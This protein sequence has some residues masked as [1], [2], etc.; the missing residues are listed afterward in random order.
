VCSAGCEVAVCLFLVCGSVTWVALARSEARRVSSWRVKWG[1]NVEAMRFREGEGG[2]W[3]SKDYIQESI[4]RHRT[5]QATTKA[6]RS[7]TLRNQCERYLY[8]S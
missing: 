5:N 6:C 4:N 7:K 3:W 1:R 8:V 2:I